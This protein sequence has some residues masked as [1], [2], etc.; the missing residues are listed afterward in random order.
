MNERTESANAVMDV[1]RSHRSV[2]SF[3]DEPIAEETVRAL[4]EAGTRASTSSNMQAYSVISI[5][6]PDLKAKVAACCA[7]QKQIHQSA[8]FFAF[9]ADLHKLRLACQR[10][11]APADATGLSE[12]LLIAVVD[13]ALV[14]QNVAVAAESMGYGICMIGAMRNQPDEVAR[15]LRLPDHV[16]GVA[17]MCIGRPAD[18]GDTK[19]RIGL[20]ATLHVNGYRSDAEL[21]ALMTD[22]D[23]RQAAWYAE[24]GM[25]ASDAR[26]TSVMAQ[27]LP[28]VAKRAG[29]DRFLKDR[30]FLSQ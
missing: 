9:C 19:P 25:H 7:D 4:I 1:L 2:R 14:M 5:T 8:A 23:E 24:R 3:S 16:F 11:D 30:G 20:D 15:L 18:E 22:Y 10:H 17:G 28:G 12:A 27:R 21:E 6:D 29:F 13:T 26:W